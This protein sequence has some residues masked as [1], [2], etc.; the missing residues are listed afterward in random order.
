[1]ASN[2]EKFYISKYHNNHQTAATL[3]IDD[4]APSAITTD[5]VI[6]PFNDHGY[7]MNNP[8]GLY[9]YFEKHLLDPFPEICGTFFILIDKHTN[10]APGTGGYQILS[11]G[12]SD[13]YVDFLK[14]INPSFD[15]A[16]HG[17]NHG[18]IENGV[19]LQEFSYLTPTDIPRLKSILEEF[20]K[21]TGLSFSG[22]KYPGYIS[23]EHSEIILE[24]LGIKWWAG[25]NGMK[26]KRTHENE[27]S[28]FGD[29]SKVL[30]FP[31]TFSGEAFKTFLKPS[32][33]KFSMLTA[34]YHQLRKLNL[35]RHLQYLYENRLVISLQEHFTTYR[36]DGKFQRPNVFDDLQSIQK[37]YSILRGADI[38]HA[39]CNKIAKYVENRDNCTLDQDQ[40]TV[41]ISYKGRYESSS[42]TLQSKSRHTLTD[43]KGNKILPIYKQNLWVY[44]NVRGGVYSI[45][46]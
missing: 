13:E 28:Y 3:M 10:H 42:I 34:L 12:F 24:K 40:S 43:N 18:K 46:D 2:P 16:F 17:T 7:A 41:T 29:S 30:N 5:G 4:L 23:N 9:H 39:S 22:G 38:W 26:N 11:N 20:E 37:T 31:T 19:F 36:I 14:S 15:L 44:P 6:R 33:G 45:T 21:R 1:M 32:K 8:E 35:E 25:H 27:F